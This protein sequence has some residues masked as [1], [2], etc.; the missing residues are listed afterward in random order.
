MS[1][2]AGDAQAS[3]AQMITLAHE[4]V[5]EIYAGWNWLPSSEELPPSM[6][7]LAAQ[8]RLLATV[9]AELAES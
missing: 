6:S 2:T 5:E 3:T 9:L 1:A 8:A 4:L 7:G